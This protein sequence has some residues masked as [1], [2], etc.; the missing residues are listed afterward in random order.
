MILRL[1]PV[2]EVP[3]FI[4]NFIRE[5]LEGLSIECRLMDKIAIPKEAFYKMR[6]QYDAKIVMDIL[7]NNAEAR[8]IDR[9]MPTMLITNYDLFYGSSSFIF[10]LE[11]P[12]RSCS[13]ISLARLRPEFYG[14][15]PATGVLAE[16][17]MKEVMHELG[18]HI[19][20]DHCQNSKCVMSMSSSVKEIDKK[21]KDFCDRCKV[22]MMTRGI[23]L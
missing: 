19:C 13:I 8:F 9:S 11:Y 12:A 15:H 18:H 1:V 3:T 23:S 10:G 17:T 22:N 14:E 5:E 7:S 2:G 4:L 6:S 16:R 20:M 21:D